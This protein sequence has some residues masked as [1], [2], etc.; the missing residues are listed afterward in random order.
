MWWTYPFNLCGSIYFLFS[1]IL[2][3]LADSLYILGSSKCDSLY[4]KACDRYVEMND[5]GAIK[6]LLHPTFPQGGRFVT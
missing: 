2:L 3:V 4:H 6:K 1:I 5:R